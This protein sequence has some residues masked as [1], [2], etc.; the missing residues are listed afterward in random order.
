MAQVSGRAGR[1]KKRGKVIIQ[2]YNPYHSII[3]Q[4]I[5]NDY[6]AM[7][8]EQLTDRRRFHY[9]PFTRLMLLSVQHRDAGVVEPAASWLADTLRQSFPK[10][11]FGPEYPSVSRVRNVYIKNIL[12]KLRRDQYLSDAKRHIQQDAERIKENKDWKQV[13]VVLNVDPL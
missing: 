9:P 5:D 8:S 2:S 4:V 1:D 10:Q 3:R 11:V 12:V 6:E 13:R 7:V